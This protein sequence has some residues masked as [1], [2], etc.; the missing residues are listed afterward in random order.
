MTSEQKPE[1]KEDSH[2]GVEG[3][4]S[5]AEGTACARGLG[6]DGA[7]SVGEAVRRPKSLEQREGVGEGDR[8]SGVEPGGYY[9]FGV[10]PESH[11]G[12]T[13][14]LEKGEHDPPRL[15]GARDHSLCQAWEGRCAVIHSAES[16]SPFPGRGQD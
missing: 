14:G 7:R 2:G 3:R 16:G 11:W 10:D 4:A 13:G 1:G 15:K 8:T 6:Q 9:N 12:A 5:Q